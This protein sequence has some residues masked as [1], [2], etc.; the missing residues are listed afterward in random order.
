MRENSKHK[1]KPNLGYC[2]KREFFYYRWVQL[3]SLIFGMVPPKQTSYF[4][5]IFKWNLLIL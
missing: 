5:F 3:P 1:N 4:R 2:P